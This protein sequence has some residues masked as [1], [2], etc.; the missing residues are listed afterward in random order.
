MPSQSQTTGQQRSKGTR[1]SGGQQGSQSWTTMPPP[2]PHD[3]LAVLY[4]GASHVLGG[5]YMLPDGEYC[6][7]DGS[8]Y[9]QQPIDEYHGIWECWR[10]GGA[11]LVKR[12]LG[13]G[14]TLATCEE[15]KGSRQSGLMPE[16]RP[17]HVHNWR[18]SE[19]NSYPARFEP[20]RC[21]CGA[22]WLKKRPRAAATQPI[23]GLVPVGALL[24]RV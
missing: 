17:R 20:Q 18:P 4:F 14:Y 16:L 7:P 10:C 19:E 15:C 2:K 3:S 21:E 22:L 12:Y 13:R 23:A 1:S 8:L 9:G 6:L 5:I 24:K 11:G